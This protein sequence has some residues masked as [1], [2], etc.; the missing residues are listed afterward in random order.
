MSALIT[1]LIT[2]AIF[3]ALNI[4]EYGRID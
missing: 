1:I 3:A 2:V 4:A